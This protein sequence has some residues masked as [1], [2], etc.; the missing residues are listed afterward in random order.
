VGIA[1]EIPGIDRIETAS[2][3][4]ETLLRTRS[5]GKVVFHHLTGLMCS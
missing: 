3:G 2:F 4:I 1:L 5:F